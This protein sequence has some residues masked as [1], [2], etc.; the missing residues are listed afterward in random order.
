M[1][2]NNAFVHGDLKEE[3]CIKLPYG[4][5]TPSSNIV[6]KLKLFIWIETSPKSMLD[7]IAVTG[8]DQE[9]ISKLKQM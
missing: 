1:D 2:V 8:F 6:C 3:V 5:H 9:A 7:D 4:M